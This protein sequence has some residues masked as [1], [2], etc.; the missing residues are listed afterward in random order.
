MNIKEAI[1]QSTF[2]SP[3][4]Q[5][6]VNLIYTHQWVTDQIKDMLK[7]YGVSMPQYNVLRILR[8][9]HPK[10][11]STLNIRE[12]MLERM[13]DVSRIVSRLEQQGLVIRRDCEKDR[14]L[15]DLYI[16]TE[17][18]ELLAKIDPRLDEMDRIVGRLND[19]ELLTLSGLLDKMRSTD[20]NS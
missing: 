9:Q 15:V 4:Q 7:P 11:L 8:G 5:V 10:P 17:G 6:I 16:S 19:Q 14:R 13:S 3:A 2:R 12:R 1:Q 18:L 20:E